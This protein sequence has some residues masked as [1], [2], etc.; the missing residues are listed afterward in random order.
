MVCFQT[1]INAAGEL[2]AFNTKAGTVL[3]TD[4]F[5]P[6][7][8]IALPPFVYDIGGGKEGSLPFSAH[9][10]IEHT[11]SKLI[12]NALSNDI[13]LGKLNECRI[14][15]AAKLAGW[16]SHNSIGVSVRNKLP[17]PLL[18]KPKVLVI[19]RQAEYDT[20][21]TADADVYYITI[22]QLNRLAQTKHN[23]PWGSLS[24]DSIACLVFPY[25]QSLTYI[26]VNVPLSHLDLHQIPPLTPY[27][28][29]LL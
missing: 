19:T 10:I 18:Q 20:L 29:H 11:T 9:L 12:S 8:R 6:Q 25:T 4:G 14:D 22:S 15:H 28:I 3:N 17:Y 27:T 2:V 26:P 5:V 21:N 23:L 1:T 16:N 7:T 13:F 24:R